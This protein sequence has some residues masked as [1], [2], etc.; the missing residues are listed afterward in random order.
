MLHGDKW[1]GM[2][3]A[4]KTSTI[5]NT[6]S[7]AFATAK[8]GG[9]QPGQRIQ[10]YWWSLLSPSLTSAGYDSFMAANEWIKNHISVAEKNYMLSFDYAMPSVVAPGTIPGTIPGTVPAPASTS[11]TWQVYAGIALVLAAVGFI[12]YKKMKKNN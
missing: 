2:N 11:T 8:T 4:T 1:S 9:L 10:D 7:Q 6:L 3:D 12:V 5:D